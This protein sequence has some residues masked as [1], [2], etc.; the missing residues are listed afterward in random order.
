MLVLDRIV[1]PY[2]PPPVLEVTLEATLE[3]TTLLATLDATLD[4]AALE[5]NA[6][7]RSSR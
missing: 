5:A 7:W 3:A 1:A 4:G 6:A 2:W